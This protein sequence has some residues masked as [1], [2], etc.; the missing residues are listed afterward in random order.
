MPLL[1]VHVVPRGTGS[2]CLHAGDELDAIA[3]RIVDVTA[4]HAGLIGRLGKRDAG[5][6]EPRDDGGLGHFATAEQLAVEPARGG[7]ATGG[8]ESWT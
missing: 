2:R 8:I 1:A 6:S 3:E 5:R 4:P 7:L